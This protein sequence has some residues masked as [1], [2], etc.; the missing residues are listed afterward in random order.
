M[1]LILDFPWFSSPIEN[2]NHNKKEMLGKVTFYAT[3]ER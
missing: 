2:S 1:Y 3:D